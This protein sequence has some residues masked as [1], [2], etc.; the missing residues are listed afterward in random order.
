[1]INTPTHITRMDFFET[2]P[3]RTSSRSTNESFP[4]H[5]YMWWYYL[6]AFQSLPTGC[7]V[8]FPSKCTPEPNTV[9]ESS[10]YE[11]CKLGVM[12]CD[13]SPCHS[14]SQRI[15]E[16]ARK[17]QSNT[18]STLLLRCNIPWKYRTTLCVWTETKEAKHVVCYTNS[19]MTV[20]DPETG[21]NTKNTEYR[22]QHV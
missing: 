11:H 9:R 1:M 17:V 6:H 20:T 10:S 7:Y 18:G 13:N 21:C 8:C 16:T 3:V 14:R 4:K 22:V 2:S 19:H 5:C 15:S 12:Y